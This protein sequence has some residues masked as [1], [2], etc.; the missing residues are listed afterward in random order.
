[1]QLDVDVDCGCEKVDIVDVDVRVFTLCPPP[2]SDPDVAEKRA[3]CGAAGQLWRQDHVCWTGSR[4]HAGKEAVKSCVRRPVFRD[5]AGKDPGTVG[6]RKITSTT[7]Q[8]K[9]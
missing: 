5:C 8:K 2:V 3:H 7:S 4:R 6:K 9:V 1:M